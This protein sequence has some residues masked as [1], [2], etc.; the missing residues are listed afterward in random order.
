MA[1]KNFGP[2]VSG[3][4]DP[5]GRNW[6]TAVFQAGKPVLDKELNLQQDV[7]GGQ[8]E[9]AVRRT[10]PSGWISDDFVAT[11]SFLDGVFV[12]AA[13]LSLVAQS[14]LV[15]HVN[16]WL[17]KIQ[18]SG[19]INTNT[20]TLTAGP[21][22][23]GATRTDLVI[24]EVWRLL[25]SAAPST[26]GKSASGRIWQQGNVKTDP[27]NDV[28]LNFA[29]DILDTAVGAESTKRVQI[30]YRFRVIPGVDL[31]GHPYGIDDPTAVAR[32]VP[33]NAATPD[34]SATAFTYAN[35]SA[36]GDPGLWRAGDGNPA[37]GLGTVDGYM[38][39][40]PF[41]AIFRRNT[42]PFDRILN[43]NG[44]AASPGPSTRPDGKFV[45]VV[46]LKDVA[47]LRL[48][49]S[50]VGWA[51]S[52]VLAKNFNA[53]LD[54]NLHTE[55]TTNTFGGGGINGSVVMFAD[56]I[57]PFPSDN[58]GPLIGN[59]DAAR[60]RFSG[61]SIYETVT[62]KIPVPLGG[63]VDGATITI[64]PTALAIYPYAA[65]NWSSYAPASVVITDVKRFWWLGAA[66][67]KTVEGAQFVQSITNLGAMPTASM[68]VTF[69]AIS[70]IGL[71]NESIF[72]DLVI[73]YPTGVGLTR[74]PVA[75]YGANS[76]ALTGGT[77][78]AGAPVSFSA[79]ANQAIDAPHREVQLEYTTSPLTVTQ[80]ANTGSGTAASV[81]SLV[82]T[83]ATITGL[84]GMNPGL[85]GQ[86]LTFSAAA[87]GGN[88]GTFTILGFVSATSVQ[89]TNAGAVAPDVNNGAIHWT[90]KSG[91]FRI[92]ERATSVTSVLKNGVAIAGTVT[93]DTGGRI[94]TFTNGADATVSGDTLQ[95]TYTAI[96]PM[97]QNNQQMT[98][99]YDTAAP[100]A[101]RQAL[102]GGTLQVIP[103][104][105]SGELYVLTTGSGSQDE[106]YPWPLGYVQT[107]GIWP[108]STNTY[109]G[110]SDLSARADVAITE[111]NATTGFLRLPVLV[112][113][114]ADPDKLFF[115]S[116]AT[117]VEGR[118][119]YKA[120]PGGIYIPNAYSQGLA[121]AVRHKDVFPILCELA[122][123]SSLGF[124]GQLVLV[125]LIRYSLFDEINGVF[126]NSDQTLN[127]TVASIF[128]I[129]GNLLDK[130]AT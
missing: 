20:L 93:L 73:A 102:L 40:I 85:V 11:A 91:F 47:D 17:L 79:Y 10:M 56:E 41:I 15:A 108:N 2:A 84:T 100:Q 35:Q 92:P 78:P 6:E 61:R 12:S 117:D 70:S 1:T 43:Q 58:A 18:H 98:V 8:A 34:G 32:T 9:A 24:L 119:F 94:A 66:G 63:W 72:I 31:F 54:D 122:A 86:Q 53:L 14:G 74:T 121:N 114:V 22:G 69:G 125:L 64:D 110:E 36:S 42:S 5:T 45:D 129:K 60:R 89:V 112:P 123:D 103:K 80:A 128:R 111:F 29:D 68:V 67:K 104:A 26:V 115:T 49:V 105:V 116:V 57:G 48:G 88:N 75:T 97:P 106:G 101:A 95:F 118:S 28:S 107:G 71:T 126:F 109:S 52:E 4:L 16:G 37:N 83:T 3:Y 113:M 7:D 59:F 13:S 99:Y 96:R 87:S 23:N 46:A 120:I 21:A 81:A 124:R 65:F 82:G 30:Q 55:W 90:L 33:T 77:L 130:R 62:V 39:A 27:A 50:P 76:F 51:L 38:Y 19:T 25:V 44:G 127:T